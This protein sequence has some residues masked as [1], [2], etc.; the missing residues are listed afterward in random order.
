MG[1]DKNIDTQQTHEHIDD[2]LVRKSE[3]LSRYANDIDVQQDIGLVVEKIY[4]I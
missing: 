1:V 4:F 2:F 3:L